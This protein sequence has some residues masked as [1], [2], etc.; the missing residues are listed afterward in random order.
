MTN[1]KKKKGQSRFGIFKNGFQRVHYT[2][3]QQSGEVNV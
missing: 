3:F 2:R 1:E